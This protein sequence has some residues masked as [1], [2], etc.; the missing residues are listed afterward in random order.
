MDLPFQMLSQSGRGR[1]VSGEELEAFGKQAAALWSSK[2]TSL[3][4]AVVET[5]KHAGL[6]PEQVR[7]VIEFANTAAYLGEFHKE[8]SPHK[9]I[10]F[11]GGPAD[12]SSVLQDLNDGGGGSVSD[13]GMMDYASPPAETKTAEVRFET[14]FEQMFAVQAP[15]IPEENPLGGIMDLREKVAGL[16]DHLTSEI[17]GLEVMHMDLCQRLFENVKQA[18]L[19]GYSLGEVVQAW[20]KV[21][22]E[23]VFFKTA[24]VMLGQRLVDNEVFPSLHEVY[25]SLEK[26]G[27]ARMVNMDHPLLTDF[28][29]YC[30]CIEKIAQLREQ[31]EKAA[32]ALR[33]T[34]EFILRPEK[35][36]EGKAPSSSSADPFE[37]LK[38]AEV[39]GVVGKA[40][41][42]G[43]K[44]APVGEAAGKFLGE[45]AVGK[46]NQTAAQIG[47]LTGKAVQYTPHALGV[48]LALRAGQHAQALGQTSLGH[49]VKSLIPGTQDYQQKKYQLQMQY[50]GGMPQYY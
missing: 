48:A 24:F 32:S 33:Q 41:Q 44:A 11:S 17:S 9:V 19:E 4:S 16:H 36:A 28:E 7:R 12:P 29:E 34:T 26:T 37:G 35:V 18:A 43:R 5:V 50:G 13:R 6:T 3:N 49:E 38:T 27:A 31:Q 45:L 23:P 46:G 39:G 47:K 22:E 25:D 8:G 30:G 42:L 20:S 21:T 10:E 1:S 14:S 15:N 40:V 2:D